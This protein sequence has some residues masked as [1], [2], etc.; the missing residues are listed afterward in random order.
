MSSIAQSARGAL[1]FTNAQHDNARTS[2]DLM[3]YAPRPVD[4]PNRDWPDVIDQLLGIRN[5]QDDWDG[6][7]TAAIDSNLTDGACSLACYFRDER[8]AVADRVCPGVNGTIFF[9]W[10]SPEMYFEVEVE[11]PNRAECRRVY[12]DGTNRVETFEISRNG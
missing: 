3:S 5:L 1:A 10:H 7:G 9:E 2:N 8:W 11:E 6:E 12:K 4:Q